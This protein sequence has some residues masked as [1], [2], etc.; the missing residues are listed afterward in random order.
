[1]CKG[2]FL[3]QVYSKLINI[4]F[5]L[6]SFA[7]SLSLFSLIITEITKQSGVEKE[8]GRG[9]QSVPRKWWQRLFVVDYVVW[10]GMRQVGLGGEVIW[11][12]IWRIAQDFEARYNFHITQMIWCLS[13]N[14]TKQAKWNETKQKGVYWE[15]VHGG[16]NHGLWPLTTA[17]LKWK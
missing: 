4:I 13:C 1:M 17:S 9:I 15:E 12:Y 8:I 14:K 10:V 3:H 6:Y 11:I 5:G 7:L 2:Q 16:R